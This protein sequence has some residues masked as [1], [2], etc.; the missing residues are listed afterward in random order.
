M[1]VT[2]ACI[3]ARVSE[4]MQTPPTITRGVTKSTGTDRFE[5]YAAT[6]LIPGGGL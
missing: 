1:A 4:D 3:C 2:M 5:K 6:D